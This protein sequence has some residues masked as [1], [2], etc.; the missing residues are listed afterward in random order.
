MLRAKDNPF[1]I[2]RVHQIRYDPP[3]TSWDNL[4]GHLAGMQYR[5]AIVGA[6]GSGKTTLSEDLQ[7]HLE[8]QDLCCLR[9]LCHQNHVL[10]AWSELN[11][12]AACFNRSL[13]SSG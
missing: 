5:G 6:C 4:L 8:Q 1:A 9:L 12:S 3:G 2:D 7:T 10:W 11:R 13:N